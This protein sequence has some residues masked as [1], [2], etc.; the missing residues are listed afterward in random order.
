MFPHQSYG[1]G[2]SHFSFST[3][4]LLLL[5][6]LLLLFSYSCFFHVFPSLLVFPTLFFFPFWFSRLQG[7]P[8]KNIQPSSFFL[9][10]LFYALLLLLLLL[11]LLFFS[12]SC[13]FH[14]FPSL[15]IFPVFFSFLIFPLA[16]W[17]TKKHLANK[18]SVWLLIQNTIAMS[19]HFS[20]LL[21]CF[22]HFDLWLKIGFFLGYIVS[23]LNLRM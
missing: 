4:L 20:F 15:L 16:R 9:C 8:Q 7:D 13:L 21:L 19:F 2:D 3:A 11:L 6:L 18:H 22:S 5:L 1:F 14:V 10:A 17:S 23:V 12:Y